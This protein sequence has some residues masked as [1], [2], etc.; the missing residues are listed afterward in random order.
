M[1][2]FRIIN[3]ISSTRYQKIENED[4]DV[5]II[6]PVTAKEEIICPDYLRH[7]LCNNQQDQD[8]MV[9]FMVCSNGKWKHVKSFFPE[10]DILVERRNVQ[11]KK[12]CQRESL[13][14]CSDSS[15]KLIDFFSGFLFVFDISCPPMVFILSI[16]QW[17]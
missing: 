12:A 13:C 8:V 11:P 16:S 6:E 10:N 15:L 7:H 4:D 1:K 9:E 17:K 3:K 2:E 5:Q 14:L